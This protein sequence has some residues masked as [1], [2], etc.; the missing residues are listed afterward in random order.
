MKITL[1]LSIFLLALVFTACDA[2]DE[3]ANVDK[4][5]KFDLNSSSEVSIPETTI[6]NTPVELDTPTIE[7][8]SSSAFSNNNTTKDLIESIKLT[9]MKLEIKSP[10]SAN[11][12]FLKE[13]TLFINADGLEKK[14]IAFK[15]NIANNDSS[16]IL[17]DIVDTELKEYLIRD[18]YV[19]NVTTTTDEAIDEDCDITISTKFLVDAKIL[20]I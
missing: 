1:K 18:N 8:N 16:F 12:N 14:Q 3:I 20:G 11:F 19:L 5:T 10:E 13:I 7:S 2:V 15:N 4:F 9:E 6:V 17:L